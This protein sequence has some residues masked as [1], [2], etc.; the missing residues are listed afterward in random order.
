MTYFE[1][2]GRENVDECGEPNSADLQD[3]INRIM[4]YE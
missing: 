1:N 3:I 2:P 4:E